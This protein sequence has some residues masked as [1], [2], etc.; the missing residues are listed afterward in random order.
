[1]FFMHIKMLSFLFLFAWMRFVLFVCVKS[2]CKKKKTIKRFKIALIPSFTTLLM[3]TPLNLP[4]VSY[5]YAL[6]FIYDHLW[7]SFLFIGIF[8]FHENLFLFMIICGGLFFLW[9]SLL[10]YDH[11]WE[12]FLFMRISPYLWS[13][14]KISS[15]YENLFN[16]SLFMIICKN[17]FLL[18]ESFW[19]SSYLWWI[20][21]LLIF[22]HTYPSVRTYSHLLFIIQNLFSFACN[23]IDSMNRKSSW[24]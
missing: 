23:H 17:L 1:M 20:I 7:G 24:T 12:S 16:F 9:E 4:M 14:V 13:S 15:F 21:L 8:S 10:I 11:L 2:S 3:Y 6:I 22:H 18:W 19:N 5:L